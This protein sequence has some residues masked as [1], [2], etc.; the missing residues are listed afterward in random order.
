[1]G[2]KYLGTHQNITLHLRLYIGI[3]ESAATQVV[4]G[5]SLIVSECPF[6]G[7]ELTQGV[8]FKF[9]IWLTVYFFA[10]NVSSGYT[11]L[12]IFGV[13]SESGL[14]TWSGTPSSRLG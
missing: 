4:T 6:Q 10:N 7:R 12:D 11:V 13:S 3:R 9:V 8:I 2:S 14:E 1:M 5:R